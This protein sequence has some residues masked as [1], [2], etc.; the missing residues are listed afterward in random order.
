MFICYGTTIEDQFEFL[1]RRWADRHFV[2]LPLVRPQR[3]V[4]TGDTGLVACLEVA[5]KL[6][7]PATTRAKI[8]AGL[9]A[10]AEGLRP[11]LDIQSPT[12][13]VAKKNDIDPMHP[14]PDPA[15]L[16]DTPRCGARTRNGTACRSPAV[17]GRHRCRMHGGARGS[18]GPLG[19]LIPCEPAAALWSKPRSRSTSGPWSG[20]APSGMTSTPTARSGSGPT[21]TRPASPSRCRPSTA[22][23]AGSG[24]VAPSSRMVR[25][26]ARHR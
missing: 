11:L 20:P 22:R 5:L 17:R 1:T 26:A 6:R 18:G 3:A 19:E 7:S 21:T 9:D 2:A 15:R 23:T 16:F 25:R 14:K 12:H 4:L 10:G 13:T 24:C 8:K